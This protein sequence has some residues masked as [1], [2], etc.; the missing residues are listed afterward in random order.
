[1]RNYVYE[2]MRARKRLSNVGSF[3]TFKHA[4]VVSR[5]IPLVFGF[6]FKRPLTISER[7]LRVD[8]RY[9]GNF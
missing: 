7:G 9:L 3:Q 8:F 6:A 5:E 4:Y 2:I 1:M